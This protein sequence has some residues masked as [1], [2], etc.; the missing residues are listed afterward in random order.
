M[1]ARQAVLARV[2]SDSSPSPATPTGKATHTG[3]PA[4]RASVYAAYGT[5][6]A[7]EHLWTFRSLGAELRGEW[8]HGLTTIMYHLYGHEATRCWWFS[9]SSFLYTCLGL[10]IY[11]RREDIRATC[12]RMQTY[13]L[14]HSVAG[15]RAL[16]AEALMWCIQGFASY[17]HDV[18]NFSASSLCS[19]VDRVGATFL[20]INSALKFFAC[21]LDGANFYILAVTMS[22]AV[23]CYMMSQ[24]Y[25]GLL[26]RE[27][28]TRCKKFD[29]DITPIEGEVTR[30]DIDF[31]RRGASRME[32]FFYKKAMLW[33]S[34]WHLSGPLGGYLI[35]EYV[36]YVGAS[37]PS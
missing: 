5:R 6:A 4:C 20:F 33:H 31:M 13:S 25:F 3:V 1:L 2:T 19:V 35:I 10:A 32:R 30:H 29:T 34:L 26:I 16:E 37:G 15:E 28:K 12:P 8:P 27:I 14:L 17:F 11:S 9:A 21:D 7:M 36:A 18:Y 24:V 22:I 23:F